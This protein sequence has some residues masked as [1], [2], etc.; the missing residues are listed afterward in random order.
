MMFPDSG[1]LDIEKSVWMPVK[2]HH[3]IFNTWL[4]LFMRT[5]AE[6]AKDALLGLKKG[7]PFSLCLTQ[8]HFSSVASA[9]RKNEKDLCKVSLLLLFR[10]LCSVD[11]D[12]G[13]LCQWPLS[14]RIVFLSSYPAKRRDENRIS[15][16]F[17]VF[18]SQWFCRRCP[19]SFGG[20]GSGLLLVLGISFFWI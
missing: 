2:L 4:P 19:S 10:S 14:L 18:A 17:E 6:W 15:H 11:C 16:C 9:C 3:F 1:F 5:E 13:R 20:Q 12:F 7:A 8:K